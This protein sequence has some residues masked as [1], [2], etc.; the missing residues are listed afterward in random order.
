[1]SACSY[2]NKKT[3]QYAKIP[4]T[5]II[6]YFILLIISSLISTLFSNTPILA[7]IIGIIL[8][9]KFL[10]LTLSIVKL[11]NF[12]NISDIEIIKKVSST[13]YIISFLFSI[14]F[15][16]DILSNGFS[17]S[18]I[19]LAENNFFGFI[20]IGLFSHKFDTASICSL[21]IISLCILLIYTK[22]LYYFILIIYFF[23]ILLF[24][25]SAK[26]TIAI[27]VILIITTI[28]YP[29]RHVTTNIFKILSFALTIMIFALL[30]KDY[31]SNMIEERSVYFI[32]QTTRTKMYTS[33][34]HIAKDYFPIGSGSG[35]FGSNPS[36]TIYFSP[37]YDAYGVSALYGA[38]ES[39]SGFLMDAWWP[40]VIAES[41]LVGGAAYFITFFYM[42]IFFIKYN[43]KYKTLT[44]LFGV[45]LGIFIIL[46]SIASAN[47]THNIGILYIS[48]FCFFYM[49]EKNSTKIFISKKCLINSL[50]T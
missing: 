41:G 21:A 38:N 48:I 32:E 18:N 15:V 10:I 45:F 9:T 2:G 12:N 28:K 36:R 26:E 40:K 11:Y 50:C 8:E 30:F 46:T 1:M 44:S 22:K 47:F 29:S 23:L 39:F 42:L 17:I 7:P 14:F 20:P 37:L 33:A 31:T 24:S 27:I 6:I 3:F 35:T 34:F 16:R 49:I 13:I 25:S 43:I 5:L 4:T 19:Y